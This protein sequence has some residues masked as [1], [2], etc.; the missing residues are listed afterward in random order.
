MSNG[1]TAL[2]ALALIALIALGGAHVSYAAAVPEGTEYVGS[3]KCRVCH[4]KEH[5]TWSKTKHAKTFAVL[6]EGERQDPDCVKCHV[7]G[8]GEPGG[9]VDEQTTPKLKDVGCEACHGPGSAHVAIAAKHVQ[10][11]GGW[12]TKIDKVPRSRCVKCHNPHINQKERVE[13]LRKSR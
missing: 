7:T 3:A 9:F 5:R 12:D 11:S 1:K 2:G 4:L 8:F 6:L 13:K 10:D